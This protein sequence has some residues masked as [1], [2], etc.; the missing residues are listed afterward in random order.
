MEKPSASPQ[1]PDPKQTKTVLGIYNDDPRNIARRLERPSRPV[2]ANRTF[3][4]KIPGKGQREPDI[5]AAPE[6]PVTF[7]VNHCRQP[8]V[9][10]F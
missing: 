5:K 7:E 10:L 2:C 1:P 3:P 6:S 8:R 4:W 9:S